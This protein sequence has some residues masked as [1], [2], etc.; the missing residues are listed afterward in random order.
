MVNLH[1]IGN[2]HGSLI[3]YIST[4]NAT[5]SRDLIGC[6]TSQE[7][8]NESYR[9]VIRKNTQYVSFVCIRFQC[10]I[11]SQIFIELHFQF[12]FKIP[13]YLGKHGDKIVRHLIVFNKMQIAY[14]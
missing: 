7:C 9:A 11:I 12:F 10:Q 13:L 8:A 1:N 4:N 2:I 3:T 5:K 6:V 14:E